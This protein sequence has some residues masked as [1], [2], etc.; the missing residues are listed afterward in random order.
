[1][2]KRPIYSEIISLNNRNLRICP[3]DMQNLKI[4][5]LLTAS[6]TMVLPLHEQQKHA[7]EID[8]QIIIF[9]L[10]FIVSR[11]CFIVK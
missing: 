11:Y 2:S 7:N 4:S 6:V 9:I 3:S 10:S 5:H 1:M 8:F